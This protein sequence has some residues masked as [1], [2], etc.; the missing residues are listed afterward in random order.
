MAGIIQFAVH[1]ET[2][3]LKNPEL[4][5]WYF[6]Y[7][8][9]DFQSR[10]ASDFTPMALV[11][12]DQ[13]VIKQRISDEQ[14]LIAAQQE[15]TAAPVSASSPLRIFPGLQRK[16]LLLICIAISAA[17]FVT[18]LALPEYTF[19]AQVCTAILLAL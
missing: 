5:E 10:D 15:L 14:K 17:L 2:I 11:K 8:R 16:W 6:A 12:A 19:L 9:K 13:E 3:D 7:L 18:L 1:L 4:L